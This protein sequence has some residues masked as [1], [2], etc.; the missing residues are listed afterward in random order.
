M[1]DIEN[2]EYWADFKDLALAHGLKACWSTPIEDWE[3]KVIGTFAVY[4]H[5][6]RSPTPAEIQ[7]VGLASHAL[8]PLLI[9]QVRN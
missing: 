6:P 1:A 5:T 4:H 2:S 7:A 3:G 9:N 8:T